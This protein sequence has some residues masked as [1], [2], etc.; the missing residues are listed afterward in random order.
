MRK[1]VL[2]IDDDPVFIRRIRSVLE[3]S[4][5]LKVV[6][7]ADEAIRTCSTWRPDLILLDVH[8][9]PGD[10]F[11]ILDDITRGSLGAPIS[12]LCLSR[13]AGSTTRLQSFGDAVFGIL[14]RE[15]DQDT[16]L[17][18]VSKALDAPEM[19]AA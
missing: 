5:D 6:S 19:A 14:K 4:V 18:A 11:Q 8:I 16:L 17:A 7:V 3:H 10:S 9:A 12:V 15:I 13:G 2:L 1:R